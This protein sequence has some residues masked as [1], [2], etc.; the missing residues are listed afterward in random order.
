VGLL[1]AFAAAS[2]VAGCGQVLGLDGID[3][4]VATDGGTATATPDAGPPIVVEDGSAIDQSTSDAP[5]PPVD[6]TSD[7]APPPLDGSVTIA[8][9]PSGAA[10]QGVAVDSTRVYWVTAGLAG[11]V[12]SV[13]KGGGA[14]T[15]IATAQASPLDVAVLGTNLYWSVT[16]AGAAPQC[17]AMTATTTGGPDGGPSCVVASPDV[18]VRMTLGGAS[19]VLLAKGTGPAANS[20]LVGVPAT[21]GSFTSVL[22]GGASQ[23]ITATSQQAF[24][25]NG[26]GNHVDALMLT[27]L[28]FGPAVCLAGCGTAAL[29]DM[30]TDVSAQT[31]LWITQN[32]GVFRAP[33]TVPSGG[34]KG[35]LLAQL[36][37]GPLNRMAR[38]ASYVY[39]TALGTSIVAVP[40]AGGTPVTLASGELSPFGI[41]VDGSSVYWGDAAGNIRKTSVPAP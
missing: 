31:L 3:Y 26:N 12:L 37:T 39:V 5:G 28:T 8:T 16:P 32:G 29:V 1:F 33:V 10:V 36:G 30:A 4:D 7:S 18:T 9:G 25:G 11:S 40:L 15:T 24:L 13:L 14:V 20:E 34:P 27:G 2:T 19:I 38:D 22:T 17:M 23:A 6:G 41:A 21:G 35:T